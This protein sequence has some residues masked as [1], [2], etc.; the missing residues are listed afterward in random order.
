ME[1]HDYLHK[2]GHGHKVEHD[3]YTYY[4]ITKELFDKAVEIDGL[5]LD[6]LPK[7]VEHFIYTAKCRTL[8][9]DKDE[10]VKT[11]KHYNLFND[12]YVFDIV[13]KESY[14]RALIEMGFKFK[15]KIEPVIFNHYSW[16]DTI[17]WIYENCSN[18]KERNLFHKSILEQDSI[19]NSSI[20]CWYTKLIGDIRFAFDPRKLTYIST[21]EIED[22]L[23][24][25]KLELSIS[26]F[27]GAYLDV[28][29]FNHFLPLYKEKNDPVAMVKGLVNIST[30][31][32]V[33]RETLWG[34]M[35]D[36]K[37]L[38]KECFLEMCR[39]E[40]DIFPLFN[41]FLKL[42][43]ETE[44]F[45]IFE[46][47][48]NFPK[49]SRTMAIMDKLKIDDE[50]YLKI[51]Y[52]CFDNDFYE[53]FRY[54]SKKVDTSRLDMTIINGIFDKKLKVEV[55]VKASSFEIKI[56]DNSD[57]KKRHVNKGRMLKLLQG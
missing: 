56:I 14:L 27:K 50:L 55:S 12:G 18:D 36:S 45:H 25:F 30:N 54:V 23:Q 19:Y 49:H 40:R 42:G 2:Y 17:I 26:D 22:L 3:Y 39:S 9:F 41:H 51:L 6:Q 21:D 16:V 10:F 28:E 31:D 57:K 52:F 37:Q 44:S 4:T 34:L 7:L 13:I 47:I 43:I 15:P 35:K 29:K 20:I 46:L 24:H 32:D 5:P 53:M 48:R 33:K 11:V 1:Y 38:Q 8:G